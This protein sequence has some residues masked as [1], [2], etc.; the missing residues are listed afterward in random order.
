MIK[1]DHTRSK[2][3]FFKFFKVFIFICLVSY[4][5]DLCEGKHDTGVENFVSNF[6]ARGGG[7][8]KRTDCFT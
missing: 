5:K 2:K 8:V 7:G 1:G 4:R 6:T 3:S